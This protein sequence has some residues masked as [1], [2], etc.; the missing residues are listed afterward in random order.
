M[1]LHKNRYNRLN[2]TENQITDLHNIYLEHNNKLKSLFTNTIFD[3]YRKW[4]NDLSRHLDDISIKRLLLMIYQTENI[5]PTCKWC[6]TIL[7]NIKYIKRINNID[8]RSRFDL[9][10]DQCKISRPWA[11]RH[12]ISNDVLVAR[13]KL[14]SDAKLEFFKTTNGKEIAKSV[15]KQNSIKLHKYYIEV[16]CS[17]VTRKKISD[18]IKCR[19]LSGEFTP[20]IHNRWTHWNANIDN[21]KYRS[22]WD[23]CFHVSNPHLL[24][25]LYRIKYYDNIL[26]KDRIYIS[27]FYDITNNILY[28][29]KPTIFYL[30]E[31]NKINQVIQHCLLNKIKF[32]WIN[33]NNIIDYIDENK[34]DTKDKLIQ[35]NKLKSQ[36]T[37]GTK[38]NKN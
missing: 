5:I 22:S 2:F 17:D 30:K 12:F 25:E 3:S 38:E 8:F 21:K 23:A 15:G 27:D 36:V 28:E 24:Y 6:N 4:T 34:F 37:N 13:G 1:Q 10:C 9:S 18:N 11:T 35:L 33:E 31:V 32:I 19:I 7:D 29:L 20:N 16:G 14:I 26:N